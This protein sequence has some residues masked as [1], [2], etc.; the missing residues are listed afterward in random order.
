MPITLTP[1]S[2]S[3]SNLISSA[4]AGDNATLAGL[5]DTV[6]NDLI[7]AASQAIERICKRNFALNSYTEVYSGGGMP[8][9]EIQLANFPVTEVTRIATYPRPVLSITNSDSTGNQRATISTTPTSLRLFRMA[10]GVGTTTD[11]LFSTYTTIAA[12][13]AAV[14]G[15]G[16]SWAATAISPYSLYPTTDLLPLQGA[17]TALAVGGGA[18]LE[19][20]TEDSP[21]WGS[22]GIFSS[23]WGY[24][25]DGPGWRLDGD[26]GYLVGSWP[27]GRLNIRI[28]YSAGFEP[29]PDDVQ[30]ACVQH[31]QDLYQ[32]SLI[33]N[34]V[35]SAKIGPFSYTTL[36]RGAG[37]SSKV[38]TLL[39]PYI[40]HAKQI[41]RRGPESI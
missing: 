18:Q 37:L 24:I 4:R 25:S 40:D 35:A 5:S 1:S 20:Y 12:L 6:L 31:C 30:E 13:A 17:V 2:P 11:L 10:S 39:Q 29:I 16:H 21:A 41:V 23:I 7:A 8:Y 28:D 14:N 3:G 15:L 32:S 19:V 27:Q 22:A 9:M 33:N 38:L 34:N 26:V 36:G